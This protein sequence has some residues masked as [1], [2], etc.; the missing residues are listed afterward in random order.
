M[1]VYQSTATTTLLALLLILCRTQCIYMSGMNS[2]EDLFALMGSV[3][4]NFKVFVYSIPQSAK[5]CNLSKGGFSLP[6]F[7]K[8][9]GIEQLIPQYFRSNGMLRTEN[10]HE[11]NAFIIEHDWLCLRIG[12]GYDYP[13][14][15]YRTQLE[16]QNQFADINAMDRNSKHH[17][18][19]HMFNG[20][21][22]GKFH[23]EPIMKAVVN[24]FPF[25]NRSGGAD[26]FIVYGLDNGPFCAGGHSMPWSPHVFPIMKLL[27]NVSII[28][29]NGYNH[30]ETK[31]SVHFET[32][33]AEFMKNNFRACYRTGLDI[34]VP[35][36]H[37]FTQME[38]LVGS[39]REFD[40]FF[41]GGMSS[42]GYE[43]SPGVRENL[44]KLFQSLQSQHHT[45]ES[46]LISWQSGSMESAFFALCPAGNACWSM[47]LYDALFKNTIP[48][49][50]AD[51][52][53]EPFERF[54]DWR[55]FTV[56]YKTDMKN[57]TRLDLSHLFDDL[58]TES[59]EWR[60]AIDRGERSD[61][62]RSTLIYR[63]LTAVR[64]VAPW[65]SFDLPANDTQE[66]KACFEKS[67][68]RI[69]AGDS[70][71]S[72]T[73][74]RLKNSFRLLTLE[75]WCRV[76]AVGAAHPVC[77]NSASSIADETYL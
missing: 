77:Q 20:D 50:L 9:F 18:K 41:Q 72:F 69:S 64:E 40:V 68:S 53:V 57:E 60:A 8:M 47:R 48:V 4:S 71:K 19:K 28:G 23:L 43:C 11:A 6:S 52:I 51:G 27:E 73:S 56:K 76:T 49:I 58:H 26:H 36:I 42:N 66:Y 2:S 65:L 13:K 59:A 24:D 35:Q 5:R 17:D 7:R 22:I 3:E 10:P 44:D 39:K 75:M 74:C 61:S 38:S 16:W 15:D 55:Q 25:F 67:T 34:T 54:L 46:P 1:L 29:N 30:G 32:N 45:A 31:W 21:S 33:H 63:K 70:T 14:L 12:N 62:D 37:E